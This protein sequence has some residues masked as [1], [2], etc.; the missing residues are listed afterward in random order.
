MTED[1][2]ITLW[3]EF[4]DECDELEFKLQE[5]MEKRY[6]EKGH[7][8]LSDELLWERQKR[9]IEKLVNKQLEKTDEGND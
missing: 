6:G 7:Y 4:D 5:E 2:W 1:Q 9:L 8:H 3:Q